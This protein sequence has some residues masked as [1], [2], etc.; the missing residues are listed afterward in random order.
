M[1]PALEDAALIKH[2]LRAHGVTLKAF[3][4]ANGFRYRDVSDVV[5]GVRKGRYGVGRDIAIALLNTLESKEP[6]GNGS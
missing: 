2:K 1:L 6:T 5:R 4:Q 3:A